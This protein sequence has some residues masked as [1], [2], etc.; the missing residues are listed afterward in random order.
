M[1]AVRDAAATGDESTVQVPMPKPELNTNIY[2][3]LDAKEAE[4][5]LYH[6]LSRRELS[7]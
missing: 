2:Y 7:V 5:I 1:A 3:F 4:R 6:F